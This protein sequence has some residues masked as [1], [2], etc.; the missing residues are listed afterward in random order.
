ME[1]SS[2]AVNSVLVMTGTIKPFV[3]VSH[4]NPEERLREY[5][6]A[7]RKYIL[8]SAFRTIIFAENSGY[9]FDASELHQLA[10]DNN[11]ELIILSLVDSGVNNMSSGE[12][13]LMKRVLEECPFLHDD[14]VLWK[15]TGRL[16]ISNVNKICQK[17][18]K[19]TNLFLYS[20]QYDSIQTW[21]FCA[22]ISDLKK[23]FL[24]SETVEVMR[25]GC[26]EYA[27]MDCFKKHKSIEIDR[28]KIYPNVVG[29]RSSGQAY[30]MSHIKYRMCQLL[31]HFGLFTVSRKRP[32]RNRD[33]L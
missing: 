19:R 5:I 27:W 22:R 33:G 7:I 32:P 31:L 26:I 6:Q 18:T 1:T 8:E 13:V 10:K 2:S 20:R 4:N 3:Q 17:H 21:F 23:Y 29:V 30:T 15:V 16:W 14:D 9:L 28:F 25:R 11:K 24:S 12:A